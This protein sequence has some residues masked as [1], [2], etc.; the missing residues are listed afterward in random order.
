MVPRA[1]DRNLEHVEKAFEG[2]SNYGL[3]GGKGWMGAALCFIES[4]DLKLAD[5]SYL[6][7]RQS[8]GCS[9]FN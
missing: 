2:F 5:L 9:L 7:T 8:Y 1:V 6:R 4:D 3:P